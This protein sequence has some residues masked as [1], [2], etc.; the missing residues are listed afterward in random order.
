M[1]MYNKWRFSTEYQLRIL[2][3]VIRGVKTSSMKKEST[4]YLDQQ[5]ISFE[6]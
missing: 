4:Y 2:N 6:W 1:V 3:I 5:K